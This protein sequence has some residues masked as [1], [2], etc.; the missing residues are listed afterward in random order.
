MKP[1][2]KVGQTLWLRRLKIYH[3]RHIEDQSLEPV[4]VRKVGRKYFS[5]SKEDHPT[6]LIEFH[7]DSWRQ[8]S[9]YSPDY[10]LYGSAQELA[11]EIEATQLAIDIAD[12][13]VYG[14][15][16]RGLS[17]DVLRQIAA[18]IKGSNKAQSSST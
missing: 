16:L 12:A 13:F 6:L 18:I 5:C 3:G 15:N 2:P 8:K 14:Q 1:C 4:I 11:D 7:L 9:E 17:L 10:A